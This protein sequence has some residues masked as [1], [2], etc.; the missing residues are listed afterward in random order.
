M[1]LIGMLGGMSWQ[2]TLEYYRLANLRVGEVLGGVH[3]ARILLDS[4]DFAEIEE[5]QRHGEWSRAGDLLAARGRALATAGAD[6]LILC[7]NT[8]HLVFD[9]I[10]EAVDKPVLHIVDA[11]A[12]AVRRAGG[13]FR[14]GLLGTAFTMEQP[15]YRDRL[16]AH[17]IETLIPPGAEDR[18]TVHRVIYD[19]LV[20]GIVD[21][22]SRLAYRDIIDRLL[23][24]G[25]E[26]IIL[27]CTE[28][29]LLISPGESPVPVFASTQIHVA[30][31]VDRAWA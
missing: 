10:A 17:G 19:E 7:T 16:A 13:V 23:R 28:I 4:V 15:F 22:Q 27:G 3:S 9:R 6:L 12:A 31:A 8:M 24:D 14:V 30:A 11:T 26:G 20:R 21:E 18:H 29:E 1:Q 2:S 25:A 5:L